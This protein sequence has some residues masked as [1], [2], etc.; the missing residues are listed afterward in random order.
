MKKIT[1]VYD[2]ETKQEK[3]EELIERLDPKPDN[4]ISYSELNINDFS[5]KDWLACSLPDILL[6]ELFEQLKDSEVNLGLLPHPKMDQGKKGFGI[7]TIFEKA[8]EEIQVAKEAPKIDL[9]LV[10]EQLAFNSLVI[11]TSLSILYSNSV[12]NFFEGVKARFSQLTKLFRKVKLKPYTITYK[13]GSNEEKKLETAAMGIIA[14]PH[15]ESNLIFRRVIQESGL[16]DGRIHVLILA[17]KSLFSLIQ[18]GLQNLFFPIKG[19]TLPSFVGYISTSEVFITSS[20]TIQFALDGEENEEKDLTINLVEERIKLLPG[21]S[22]IDAGEKGGPTEINASLLP[23]GRLK[24]ELLHSYLPWVRHATSDEF[25]E[26]FSLLRKNSQTTSTYLVLMA[27]STM[28]ATFGLFGDSAPVVIGAMILAPLMGPIISLAMGALRQDALLIKNSMITIFWGIILGL[29]FS[30]LITLITPLEILNN[31]IT[32]RIRPNLLDL[33]IAIASGIAGAYA[34]SKEEISKTLAGVAIS[35]ALVP[36]LAVAGIGI[37]WVDWNVFWGAMLLL[38]TNLAG[39]VM[40]ASL[41]FLLLGFT[42]FRLAKRGLLISLGISIIIA[43][44]LGLSFNEMVKENNIIQNLSGKE[45]PHGL[46]REVK[47]IQMQPLKL[48]VTILS[49]KALDEQDFLEIRKEIEAE[50]DQEIALELTL[51]V[52]MGDIEK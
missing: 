17:P 23:T 4:H 44:P 47:V 41:T 7:N 15:C 51:G 14:V 13:N 36:P 52:R 35:V 31:Q 50:I 16:D 45:I 49:E 27:L 38:G 12:S 30:I 11:G 42:P 48:S 5:S 33:G 46:L 32:A 29:I 9:M 28:I 8:W 24:E 22:L 10:N 43:L 37:G 25:K 18:F 21:A 19:G 1:F 39:I 2:P 6:K 40:A 3:L 20:E 34:Y 26:L